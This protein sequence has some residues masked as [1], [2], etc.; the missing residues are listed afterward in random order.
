[1]P[2]NA[3]GEVVHAGKLQVRGADE[4]RKPTNGFDFDDV[5]AFTGD[6]VT[7]EVELNGKSLANSKAN[8]SDWSFNST[9]WISSRSV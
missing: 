5:P 7:H 3:R 1:M 4:L 9:T 2:R 8:S 6:R